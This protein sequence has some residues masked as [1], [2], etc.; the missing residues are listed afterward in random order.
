MQRTSF[1]PAL[2]DVAPRPTE[3]EILIK[4]PSLRHNERPMEEDRL[5]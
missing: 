1:L 2:L 4:G 3:K 5:G